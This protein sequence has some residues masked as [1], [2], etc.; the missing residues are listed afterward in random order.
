MPMDCGRALNEKARWLS[1]SASASTRG[2]GLDSRVL[3]NAMLATCYVYLNTKIGQPGANH[4]GFG[5]G[6][7]GRAGKTVGLTVATWVR[8]LA[9][10]RPRGLDS[11]VHSSPSETP[12]PFRAGPAHPRSNAALG[13]VH[14]A[15]VR[16]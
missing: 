7:G 4:V 10:N 3:K 6:R 12:R 1:T 15:Q 11:R 8:R 9:Q 5:P 14:M 13:E 2:L 16:P